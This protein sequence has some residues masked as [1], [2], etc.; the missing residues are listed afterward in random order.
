MADHRAVPTSTQQLY[1]WRTVARSIFQFVVAVAAA[2]PLIYV[3]IFSASPEAATGAAAVAL[4]VS[5]AITRVMAL[6]V[7]DELLKRFAPFLASEPKS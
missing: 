2:A 3:A 1:P 6:P 4:A 5:G 7:V